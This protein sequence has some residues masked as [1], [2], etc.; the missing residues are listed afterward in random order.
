[1]EITLLKEQ[2][3]G[4]VVKLI[5]K[6]V[7]TCFKYYYPPKMV[8]SV[9]RVMNHDGVKN[10]ASWTHFYVAK[11]EDKIVGCGAIGPYWNSLTESSLFS[12]FVD[13]DY[14]R[15]GIGTK[16]IDALEKD[17]YYLRAKRIEV[18]SSV[19][20]IPFY[21]SLGYRY[22]NNEMIFQDGNFKL[23]KFNKKIKE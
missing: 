1:M 3:I 5:A 6:T 13:P 14:Q 16:I 2:E 22:K 19:S 15:Q 23:E 8:N 17:E 12:I 9:L 7:K 10:R 11:I 4:E 21:L 18:P 20:A